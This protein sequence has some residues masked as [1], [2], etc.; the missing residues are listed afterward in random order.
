[1]KGLPIATVT[2]ASL[3]VNQ[4]AEGRS[5]LRGVT[6]FHDSLTVTH[7]TCPIKTITLRLH[8]R[9]SPYITNTRTASA[10]VSRAQNQKG[11]RKNET[12]GF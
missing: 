2:D 1:M 6:V 11:P 12:V 5:R 10:G 4:S 8:S 3:A 9:R 7:M